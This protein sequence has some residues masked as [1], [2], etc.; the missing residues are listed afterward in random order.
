[1]SSPSSASLGGINA[2]AD[3]AKDITRELKRVRAAAAA[4]NK[5]RRLSGF[6]EH[7]QRVAVRFYV[8]AAHVAMVPIMFLRE[9]QET[10]TAGGFT[11]LPDSSLQDL[12]ETWFLALSDG[13]MAAL[14]APV[15]SQQIKLHD[16]AK[17]FVDQHHLRRWVLDQNINNGLAPT[18]GNMSMQYDQIHAI[19]GRL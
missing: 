4:T 11:K 16:K 2:L 1:M 8:L 17:T 9:K 14:Q 10:R 18:S 13:D 12:V 19:W 15:T 7:E 6:T 5:R 3:N